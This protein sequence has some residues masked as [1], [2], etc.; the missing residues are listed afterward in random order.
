MLAI[1]ISV[2]MQVVSIKKGVIFATC[3]GQ[4]KGFKTLGSIL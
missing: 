4:G 1:Q 3:G 2:G